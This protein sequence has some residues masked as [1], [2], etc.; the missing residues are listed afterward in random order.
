[1]AKKL[2]RHFIGIEFG[3]ELY[4]RGTQTP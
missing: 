1:M 3:A 2:Q 4:S